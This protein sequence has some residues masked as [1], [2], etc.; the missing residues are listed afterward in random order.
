[1]APRDQLGR[2]QRHLVGTFAR[3]P[4]GTQHVDDVVEL[5]DEHRL[6]DLECEH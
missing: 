1:M 3:P 5:F 6:G 2:H 4:G